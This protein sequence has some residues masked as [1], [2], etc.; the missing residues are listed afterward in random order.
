MASFSH[1]D[2][3]EADWLALNGRLS[4]F[5]TARESRAAS[6]TLGRRLLQLAQNLED[7]P[8]LQRALGVTKTSGGDIHYSTA[9]GLIGG[10][11]GV[12]ETATVLAYL[13]Q[14][15]SGLV[16]AC[17]RLMPLGQ[18]QASRIVWR[19]KPVLIDLACYSEEVAQH[20]DD[21]VAFTP[22]PDMASMRHPT[23]PTRLFIS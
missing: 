11:L 4:A 20:P 3:F 15:L 16:A 22:L 23:L 1:S 13:Q 12:E 14:S 9:F 17:Q 5:K 19:L 2:T 18:S 10:V 6:A 8:V 21:I 7:I